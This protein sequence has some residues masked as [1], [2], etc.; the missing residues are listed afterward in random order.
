MPLEGDLEYALA[1]IHARHG[2]RP[3]NAQWRSLEASR[4]LGH[5]LDALASSSLARWSA[6][7]DASSDGHAIERALRA[8]WR[9][10]VGEVA[11]WHPR[12]WQPWVAW[13]A[14][15]PEL[16]LIAAFARPEPVPPWILLDPLLGPLAPGGPEDRGSAMRRTP[17]APLTAGLVNPQA[18]A[19]LWQAHWRRLQPPIDSDIR[20]LM[21]RFRK[22]I[23]R[24][25][26]ALAIAE[27]SSVSREAL[28][29]ELTAL[30]RATAGTAL[31]SLCHLALVALDLEQ[32]RGGLIRRCLFAAAEAQRRPLTAEA[33]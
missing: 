11:S 12:I 16:P 13:L 20:A 7:L 4:D 18:L 31:A 28:T 22:C 8:Q 15:V 2:A 23:D 14:W 9:R 3:G 6:T 29:Y 24:H 32:L 21:G 27:D 10:Y 1:R 25:A 33:V 26:R 5:Y 19:P 30:F 17:L